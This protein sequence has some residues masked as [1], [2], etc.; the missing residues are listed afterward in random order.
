M[1][2]RAVI[3]R[4]GSHQVNA[5]GP[6]LLQVEIECRRAALMWGLVSGIG[7]AAHYRLRL[8]PLNGALKPRTSQPSPR[9]SKVSVRVRNYPGLNERLKL[10]GLANKCV[11]RRFSTSFS[12]WAPVF[13]FVFV[14]AYKKRRR[15]YFE[16]AFDS[17]VQNRPADH[18]PW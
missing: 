7:S 5:I 14:S 4:F 18:L 9:L 10:M 17:R 16:W 8:T 13:N 12:Q 11:T 15:S 2:H 3:W 1:Y 6:K